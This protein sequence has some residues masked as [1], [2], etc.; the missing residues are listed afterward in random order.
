MTRTLDLGCGSSP[1]NP[2]NADELFGV[3]VRDDLDSNVKMADLVIEPIPYENESFEYLTA[4]DFIEHIP[5][6]VYAPTRRNAFIELMNE[7]YRVLKPGGL[8][9]SS[10]PAY[11]HPWA[12][13]DPTHVNYVTDTTFAW[14]FD[15]TNRWGRIYGF[16][17]AFRVVNQQLRGA[18]LFAILQK[19]P[20]PAESSD[21]N[22]KIDV[23]P[24]AQFKLYQFLKNSSFPAEI[25][26]QEAGKVIQLM[27]AL[28]RTFAEHRAEFSADDVAKT[29]AELEKCLTCIK[30]DPIF[31][32]VISLVL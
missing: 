8:F 28:K 2:F 13:C 4:F 15:D 9:V 25:V 23:Y 6:V 20:I 18:H 17:G 16:N 29:E 5:R 31:A 32:Q 24:Y 1:R 10:T 7:V 19:V 30:G 22:R 26:H 27:I 3:D 11:P 14:Y 12:F 21:T